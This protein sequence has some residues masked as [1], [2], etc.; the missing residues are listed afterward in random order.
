[1][2]DDT[3]AILILGGLVG[4][5]VLLSRLRSSSSSYER[6]EERAEEASLVE[7]EIQRAL[8]MERN[9]EI[10]ELYEALERNHPHA[11]D[12]ELKDMVRAPGGPLD[13]LDARYLARGWDPR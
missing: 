8:D 4:G 7:G 5:A 12:D 1:M 2:N 11:S 10:E 13:Q 6:A 3:K 9:A